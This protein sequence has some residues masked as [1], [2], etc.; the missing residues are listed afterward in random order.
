[1]MPLQ[2][3][4]RGLYFDNVYLYSKSSIHQPKYEYLQNV[5]Q[6]TERLQFCTFRN[7]V[8]IV[9]PSEE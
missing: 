1:M 9:E 3:N 2:T 8:I 5:L 4:Q 6:P 7:N